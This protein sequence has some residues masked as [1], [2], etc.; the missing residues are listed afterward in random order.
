[1][2]VPSYPAEEELRI[3]SLLFAD[4][5]NSTGFVSAHDEETA[6]DIIAT[7][8]QVAAECVARF[9]GKVNRITGDGIMAMFGAPDGLAEHALAACAAALDMQARLRAMPDSVA[10]R[11]GVHSGEF[12]IHPLHAAGLAALD[13]TGSAVHIA[14]RLQQAA[15]P[16]EALISAATLAS[17]GTAI[18][19]EALEPHSLRG[20]S[21][22][23]E[24]LSLRGADLSASRFYA[25]HRAD[26]AFIGRVAERTQ[27]AASLAR[28]ASGDGHAL[29]VLGEAGIGKS[30]LARE[31]A[32]DA[33]AGMR[34][35]PGHALR[36]RREATLHPFAE[37]ILGAQG[38]SSPDP[39]L[40]ALLG[41]EPQDAR[42]CA[43][44]PSERRAEIIAAASVWVLAAA[45]AGPAVVILD[46]L[47][48]ADDATPLLLERL[49]PAL[50]GRPL[51]LLLL[52]RPEHRLGPLC[53][54][55][56]TL[57]LAPLE[58]GEAAALAREHGA[59][60]GQTGAIAARCGGNPFLIEQAA[61]LGNNLPPQAR[62]L[63]VERVD[64]LPSGARDVLRMLAVIEQAVSPEVLVACLAADMEPSTV[65][66]H[67]ETLA[68]A[69]F[70]ARDGLGS[71]ARIAPRHTLLQ[72]VVY[73]GLTRRRR[74]A[75]H[76]QIFERVAT[77]PGIDAG[78][79]A[80]HSWLGG[81]WA[82]ALDRN[83]AAARSALARF[84]NREAVVLLDRA[85]EALS[86]LP[87]T[88]ALLER[89]IDLRLLQREPLF[90]LGENDRLTDRLKEAERLGARMA[91]DD[92]VAAARMMQAHHAWVTG[93]LE[94][95][96]RVLTLL[97]AQG[98][99]I[100]DEALLLRC[101]FQ[102]GII[103][104]TRLQHRV[105]AAAMAAV[106]ADAADPR[107]G[108]R[109]G[110]DAPLCVVALSYQARE[111]ANA[112]DIPAARAA[113]N[114]CLALAQSVGRPFSWVFATLADGHVMHCAGRSAEAVVRLREALPHC[115]K[116]ETD[117]MRVIALVLL[118]GA[119]LGAGQAAD[120][121]AH[122]EES[123]RMADGMR[124]RVLWDVRQALL[125]RARQALLLAIR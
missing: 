102:R 81:L 75:Q 85:I 77:L 7:A 57:N 13:A 44:Q 15:A 97:E 105:C 12:L 27:L 90:R 38:T 73:R 86:N 30:R 49:V 56:P 110:L 79:L 31:V 117:M 80:R 95:S 119:E 118:A 34:I 109:Y 52:S 65:T 82:E 76:A 122:L 23:H 87:E 71:S 64:R 74:Q 1:M 11:I 46:D 100:G 8:I 47:H 114:E 3:G 9:G 91:A 39:A 25:Q 50:V 108:G 92:R 10:L 63:L 26:L 58:P 55:L 111:L 96:E 69:G 37:L 17:A 16:G 19:A 68:E 41:E 70:L 84:A 51:L 36:W 53:R 43:L 2:T 106:A 78:I 42:W 112:G 32:A 94:E 72:E 124:F 88:P 14:A 66:T 45:N 120:A 54:Q 6:H 89:S 113:A 21:G 40:A 123:Q 104:M 115:E 33:P 60:P 61:A 121:L 103:A 107:H 116:A 98:E 24:V 29:L 93:E 62:A 18:I 20:L 99:A 5:V 4:I 125:G 101:L 83:E 22:S 35:L 59:A 48:W 28:A 67:L